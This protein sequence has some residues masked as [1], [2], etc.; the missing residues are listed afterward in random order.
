MSGGDDAAKVIRGTMETL[1]TRTTSLTIGT[2][3]PLPSLVAS[4]AMS[5]AAA[6]VVALTQG[7]YRLSTESGPNHVRLIA[8]PAADD[9]PP[10]VQ[11]V[12]VVAF[13]PE[14]GGL[15]ALIAAFNRGEVDVSVAVPAEAVGGLENATIRHGSGDNTGLLF[16]NTESEALETAEV[17]RS[18]AAALNHVEIAA[19]AHPD[20]EEFAALG[21][22]PPS[23]QKSKPSEDWWPFDPAVAQGAIAQAAL[24][25]RELVML[26]P[27]AAPS[28]P[29]RSLA[30]G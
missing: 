1:V 30:G 23:L 21:L 15:Q 3:T 19:A 29:R 28:I 13:P 26:T 8:G 11:E 2:L 20:H 27:W 10:P 24:A 17:R 4:E 18:L 22:L 9:A 16:L 7:P 25:G 5:T 14:E 6:Q 12:H